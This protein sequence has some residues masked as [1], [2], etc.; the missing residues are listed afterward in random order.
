M[1]LLK[2]LLMLGGGATKPSGGGKKPL[3]QSN[4]YATTVGTIYLVSQGSYAN[5][6]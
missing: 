1:S 6:T 3:N 5:R 4:V 2:R